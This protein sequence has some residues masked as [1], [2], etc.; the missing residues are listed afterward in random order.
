[1][2][3]LPVQV[4]RNGRWWAASSEREMTERINAVVRRLWTNAGAMRDMWTKC[5]RLYGN[6]PSLG[7]NPKNYRSAASNRKM[8]AR[9][10]VN[11]CKSCAD[12][13]T[14][15][16]IEDRPKVTFLTSDGDFDLQE[17][18]KTLESFTQGV[19]YDT[20]LYRTWY[21]EVLF[22]AI[23]GTGVLRGMTWSELHPDDPEDRLVLEHVPPWHILVDDEDGYSGDPQSIYQL[24]YV[25]RSY[26]KA[27]YPKLAS[28]LDT[29]G[30]LKLDIDGYQTGKESVVTDN[31][32]IVESWHKPTYKGA[33]D[34]LHVISCGDLVL[35]KEPW[36]TRS[37]PFEFLYRQQPLQGM[38]GTSLVD[39][40]TGLQREINILLSKISRSHKLLA[41]GHWLVENNAKINTGSINDDI[42]TIIRY[43]GTVPQFVVP[44]TVTPDVYNHLNWLIS[45]AYEQSGISEMSAQSLK[46]QGLD[47]GKAIATFADVQS[48]R[49]EV[50]YRESQEWFLR[51]AR[52]NIRICREA[53]ERGKIIK[54]KSMHRNLMEIID[55]SDISLQDDEYVL[56]LFPTNAL[57]DDPAEKMT[58]VSELMTMQVVRSPLDAARL[59]DL[60]DTDEW[61]KIQDASHRRTMQI[62]MGILKKG[63]YAPPEPT[64]NNL[65]DAVTLMRDLMTKAQS[66]KVGSDKISLMA[67]WIA[68]AEDHLAPPPHPPP[69]PPNPMMA[70]PPGAP[71]PPPPGMPAGPL[72]PAAPP[73]APPPNLAA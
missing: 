49:F 10:S 9:L 45:K 15:M 27:I 3:G 55:W 28:R 24:E 11:V 21:R 41:V 38:W 7:L 67:R 58:Q 14:A 19:F 43:T 44:S 71:L 57:A 59:M 47:S 64:M 13:Y 6:A 66:D 52:M 54:V 33:K 5:A 46:P 50:N 8:L 22:T 25:E 62:A 20:D 34:G 26:L 31:V 63:E 30:D 72:P 73:G 51:I 53:K 4:S 35:F 68:Q 12:A 39:E 23:F 40:L 42:G 70:P 61:M 65:A 36:L 18:A 60:P 56:K 2:M 1:M 29:V 32:V 69:P 37:F 48:Q 17:E 16:I